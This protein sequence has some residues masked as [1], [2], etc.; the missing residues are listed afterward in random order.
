M[1]MTTVVSPDERV[2][3]YLNRAGLDG[4]RIVPL[5]P[6]ASDRRYVRVIAPHGTTQVLAVYPGSIEYTQMPFTQVATLL[7]QMPVP[8]PHVTGHDDALGIVAQED[9]GDVTL[10]A[11]LV[12]ATAAGARALYEE[13]IAII[14][15]LQRRGA[16]LATTAPVP[17]GLAFDVPKLMFELDF[18]ATHFLEGHRGVTFAPAD[19]AALAEEFTSLASELSAEPRVV[20]HR[21]Y[22]SRNLMVQEGQLGVIDFQDARM[23]PDTYDLV[24]LLRDSYVQLE[25][26]QVDALIGRFLSLDRGPLG[27]AGEAARFRERFD[28]MAV[29]RNLKALGTFGYQASVRRNAAYLGDVPRTLGYLRDTFVRRPRFGRLRALLAAHLPELESKT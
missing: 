25:E 1:P 18:F 27:H 2:A 22:H 8:I 17:Y 3:R 26:D 4:A 15:T 6:D 13:A 29:Q 28:T 21:D 19:R 12:T 10:Q 24:S 20:C 16:E 23:G 9:L 7:Q 5:T 11:H 14:A